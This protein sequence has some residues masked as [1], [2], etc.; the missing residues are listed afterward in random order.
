MERQTIDLIHLRERPAQIK[1]QI[2]L[3]DGFVERERPDFPLEFDHEQPVQAGGAGQDDRVVKLQLGKAAF[4]LVRRRPL[5]RPGDSRRGPGNALCDPERR[6]RRLVLRPLVCGGERMHP[7]RFHQ[8]QPPAQCHR[9]QHASPDP[10]ALSLGRQTLLS[11][12]MATL[13]HPRAPAH[14]RHFHVRFLQGRGACDRDE[15][16]VTAGG[17]LA[18]IPGSGT[19]RLYSRRPPAN[20]SLRRADSPTRRLGAARP[21]VLFPGS[22]P[23]VAAGRCHLP[24]THSHADTPA[25]WG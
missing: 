12:P 22:W 20:Q 11:V 18:D 21:A 19:R 3:R 10:R 7:A 9:G 8:R 25:S 16:P 5:R 4:E 24:E 17:F 15:G 14:H 1:E 6:R 23:V 13:S 2:G